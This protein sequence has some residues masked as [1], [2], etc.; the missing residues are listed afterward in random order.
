MVQAGAQLWS[1]CSTAL[2]APHELC[3]AHCQLGS[4]SGWQ[5]MSH[6]LDQ[7]ELCAGNGFSS[8]SPAADVAHPVREA[9]DHEGGYP[10]TSQEFGAIA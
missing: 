6:S 7:D 10:E 3:D 5:V 9:V 2:R 8:R 4:Q 1:A